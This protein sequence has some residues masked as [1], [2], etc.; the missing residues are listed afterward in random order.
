[1]KR[2]LL[3]LNGLRVLDA[4]AR[5]LSFTKAADE[6]AVTPAAVGQQIRGIEEQLGVVLFR[7][8]TRGLEP[9]AE[10]EAGLRALREGFGLLE[11]SVREMRSGQVDTMLTIAAPRALIAKW[12][13][14][15]LSDYRRDNPEMQ[16][17]L[18]VND[19]D[20]D[21]DEAN[22]D[23][24]FGLRLHAREYEHHMIDD[25]TWV[26][27]THP[28]LELE[29]E[30]RWQLEPDPEGIECNASLC[31]ADAALA[32]D[33]VA[34]GM[35]HARVPALL[36]HTDVE[37]G[38]IRITSAAR[39]RKRARFIMYAPEQLWRQPKVQALLET[40]TAEK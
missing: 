39:N 24:A 25:G 1:M 6:L 20:V 23:L 38:A 4:A 19:L 26:N 10:C 15:R 18:L 5:H 27:I 2:S 11:H 17:Q 22:V 29:H 12:L 40:L 34:A 37:N 35:G 9:T 3:P 30:I 8:T 14:D 36:T 7:R 16:F 31:V 28:E 13:I 33:A 32:I 21:F